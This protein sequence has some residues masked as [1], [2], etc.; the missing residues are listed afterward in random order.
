VPPPTL[1]RAA[2]NIARYFATGQLSLNECLFW[3]PSVGRS[4]RSL[5]Q[6]GNYDLVIGDMVRS[7]PSLQNLGV[8]V[9]LDLDDR[10]SER[11]AAIADRGG[12]A[13]ELLGIYA[14]RIPDP[15]KG[16]VT[17]VARRLL[18]REAS[19][20]AGREISLARTATAVSMVS[21]L[22][23]ASLERD[24][25]VRVN[26]L[27]MAIAPASIGVDVAS[28]PA[29]SM[30]FCGG[31]DYHANAEA[32]RWFADEVLPATLRALPDFSLSVVGACPPALRAELE[33]PGLT[34][35]GYVDDL[36][37]EL[38]RHRAFL[39]P[40]QSG[41]GIKT[42]VL[43]AMGLGL[44]VVCTRHGVTGL[45]VAHAEQCLIADMPKAFVSC[46]VDLA[47]LP[48]TAAAVGD[49]GRQY[50][51][52]HFSYDVIAARWRGVLEAIDLG[53]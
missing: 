43:E 31:L 3:S 37:S 22:E 35:L 12:G 4:I 47:R 10:L 23:A 46:V 53:D 15:L 21:S 44:P 5:V 20:L 1:S 38:S 34:C 17:W 40:L 13:G 41:T 6:S 7:A 42:K 2:V 36:E 48:D 24:A 11:Y 30:V 27:P 32:M 14:S 9:L 50:V 18:R 33:R 19:V 39:A 52:M 16:P 49:A 45:D 51:D 29:S 28:N 8:P 26:A 25:G